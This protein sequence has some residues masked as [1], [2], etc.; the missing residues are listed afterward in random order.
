MSNIN[1]KGINTKL[2]H[3]GQKKDPYTNC[4]T[5]PIYQTSTFVFDNANQGAARFSGDETGYIYTRLGNPT[6][7]ILEDKIAISEGAEAA[8]ATASGI[9]AIASAIWSLLSSGDHIVATKNIYGC[10]FALLDEQLRKFNIETSFVDGKDVNSFKEAIRP[11]TKLILVETPSNPT[12]EIVN[13]REVSKIAHE[14]DVKLMVDNTFLSPYGQNPL[15]LGADIVVH[16]ATKYL[17]GHGDVIAGAVVGTKEFIDKVRMEG[18]K[19]LTGACISPFNAWLIIRGMKTLGIRMERHC[20]NAIKVAK[21]LEGHEKIRNIYYPGLESHPQYELAKEQMK[22][23][24]AIISFEIK[25]GHKAAVELLDN[26]EL[27]SIAVSLG[28]TETLI[29]HPASMTHSCIPRE[30]RLEAGI[31]DDLV[32]I[33]VGLEDAE[34]IIDDLQRALSKVKFYE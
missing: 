8:I 14:H 5:T 25:G 12:L 11:N 9:G 30:K 20:S 21:F 17:N 22:L 34:D 24:G 28:D 15:S 19:D 2:V 32:R 26:V 10:T 7:E 31:S 23:S 1:C 33:S 3:G 13:I 6:Q 27:C 16:S 18:V 29:Q 4:L